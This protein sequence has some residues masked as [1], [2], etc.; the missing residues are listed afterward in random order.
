MLEVTRVERTQLTHNNWQDPKETWLKVVET[1]ERDGVLYSRTSG[2]YGPPVE[3]EHFVRVGHASVGSEHPRTNIP[4]VLCGHCH[5]DTF[6]LT[7]GS[8][9][10]HATC[11]ACGMQDIVYDG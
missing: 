6:R 10:L 8:Y 9:C 11:A 5:E 7:Y 2:M 4:D 3:H 1:I